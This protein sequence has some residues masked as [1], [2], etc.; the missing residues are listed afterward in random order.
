MTPG[1]K[2]VRAAYLK[3]KLKFKVLST[4]ERALKNVVVFVRP[5]LIVKGTGAHSI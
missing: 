2:I 5:G 3:D 1:K 4:P